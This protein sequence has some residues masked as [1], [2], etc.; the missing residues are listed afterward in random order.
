MVRTDSVDDGSVDRA[1]MTMMHWLRP[2][3]VVYGSNKCF[4]S[5]EYGR[6]ALLTKG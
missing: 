5:C 4:T 3:L 6:F 1:H 2:V